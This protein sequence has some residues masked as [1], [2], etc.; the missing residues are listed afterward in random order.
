M[1][2]TKTS[3]A[4]DLVHTS[5]LLSCRF[6]PGGQFVFA[7]AQDYS[8][9]RLNIADGSKT[10]FPAE[11]WVRAI[12]FV[13]NGETCLTAGYD[14]RLMWWPTKADKPQA[15]RV[16]DAHHGWIRALDVSPDQSM[17][18]TVGN[19]LVVKLWAS[20]DGTLKQEFRGHESFI[21]NVAFHP[22]GKQLVTGDLM[23]NVMHW[24]LTTGQQ[25]RTWKAES[26][27]KYDKTFV[28]NIGGFRGMEFDTDGT[29]LACS[30]ITN[31]SNAFAGV[32]NPSVVVFDWV[33]GEQKIEHL[34]KGKLQGTAW[35]VV[36]HPDGT[37]IAAMGG[38]GGYLLFWKPDSVD[39]FHNIKLKD[40]A[41]DLAI[42]SEAALVA[43]AHSNGHVSVYQIGG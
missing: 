34:S 33:K 7:G 8:V 2:I 11:S 14:G 37:R 41:R 38:S 1:D 35:G 32:G 16:V 15:S 4:H 6:D 5:P 19:D 10:E 43:T 12:A 30:G 39:E 40:A 27:Q 22:D 20:A 36:F 42:S 31:V 18:A 28:A 3:L 13:D 25:V 24:D 26:L 23:C 17:I 21:Y 9:W 29:W